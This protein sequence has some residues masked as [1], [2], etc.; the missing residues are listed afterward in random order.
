MT[1]AVVAQSVLINQKVY[2]NELLQPRFNNLKPDTVDYF[3][4]FPSPKSVMFKSM[5]LPGWGQVI[6]DQI[7]KVPI[8][9]GLLGGLVYYNIYLTKKYHDYRAAYYNLNEESPDD[10]RFGST[11]A[12]L[13]SSNLGFLKAQRNQFRNQRDL[14]YAYIVLAYGLNIIDAYVFA[15]LKPFNV[16][17]DLSLNA[18]IGPTM[19]TETA[20]GFTLSIDV[21]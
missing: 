9:Y 20:P 21:F 7:W 2:Y 4:D 17:K 14:S 6:N 10:F 8:I 15:H 3:P 13:A 19:V 11:P 1:S 5:I 12:Y 16:S 18:S